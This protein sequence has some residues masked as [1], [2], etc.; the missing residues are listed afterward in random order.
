MLEFSLPCYRAIYDSVGFSSIRSWAFS[1]HTNIG[2]WVPCFSLS[3][4]FL[5]FVSFCCLSLLLWHG[6]AAL[7]VLSPVWRVFLCG[8]LLFELEVPSLGFAMSPSGPKLRTSSSCFL[9]D[10]LLDL[11]STINQ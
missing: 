11:Q 2:D 1:I 3:L 6:L 9:A 5:A 7:F 10:R 8:F 4:L